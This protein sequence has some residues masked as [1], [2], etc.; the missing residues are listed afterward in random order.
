MKVTIDRLGHLGDGVAQG[1]NGT[2]FVPG[3]LPGEEVEGDL[4]G[5]FGSKAPRCGT[6][7]IVEGGGPALPAMCALRA[8]VAIERIE[9][10]V[11]MQHGI[12]LCG[13]RRAPRRMS[14]W[15]GLSPAA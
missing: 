3:M 4:L 13:N 6:I 7:R 11:S 14:D 12:A 5:V 10:R 15:R 1:P 2:I 9:Q 8:E